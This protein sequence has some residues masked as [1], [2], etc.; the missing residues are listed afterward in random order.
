MQSAHPLSG[1]KDQ[2]VEREMPEPFLH[3][4]RIRS[5]LDRHHRAAQ[6]LGTLSIEHPDEPIE[7]AGFGE[8]NPA[9]G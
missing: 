3:R 4:Q 5:V 7:L 2:I 6:S 8:G 1:V 9:A